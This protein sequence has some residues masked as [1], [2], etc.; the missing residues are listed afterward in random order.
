MLCRVSPP[1]PFPSDQVSLSPDRASPLSRRRN[2]A[3]RQ[4]LTTPLLAFP[5]RLRNAIIEPLSLTDSYT[6]GVLTFLPPLYLWG[7]AGATEP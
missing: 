6:H 3:A 2:L 4:G 5:I 1:P 7:R